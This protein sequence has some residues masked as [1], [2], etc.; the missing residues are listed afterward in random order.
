MAST[1]G[2]QIEID[3]ALAEENRRLRFSRDQIAACVDVLLDA[4]DSVLELCELSGMH[5]EGEYQRCKA[6]FNEWAGAD[7]IVTPCDH[8]PDE[9]G[10][11][12][13]CGAMQPETC[14]PVTIP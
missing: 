6:I 14:D 1:T 10:Q 11:C 7:D 5:D 8:E 4:L 9:R 13:H 12:I 2:L 3:A